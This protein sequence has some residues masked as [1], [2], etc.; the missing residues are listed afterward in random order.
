MEKLGLTITGAG[1]IL[2]IGWRQSQR[3]AAG[4][5]PVG[6]T[7]ERLIWLLLRHGIP[8]QWKEKED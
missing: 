4:D 3:L 5:T 6:V 2:G 1:P 8:K 7:I